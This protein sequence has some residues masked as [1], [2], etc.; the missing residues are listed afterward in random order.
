MK[1]KAKPRSV[2]EF[3]S[4]GVETGDH[5]QYV[6]YAPPAKRQKG[7]MVSDVPALVAALKQKGLL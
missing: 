2:I 6:S 3:D 5:L 4:L 7:V 1:A